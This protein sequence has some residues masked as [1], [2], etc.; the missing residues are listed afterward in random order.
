MDI[1]NN[2]IFDLIQSLKVYKTNKINIILKKNKKMMVYLENERL[3]KYNLLTLWA[4]LTEST[5]QCKV[6]TYL[7][8]WTLSG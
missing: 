6:T 1:Q 7:K 8:V 4:R 5:P 2:Y 3:L